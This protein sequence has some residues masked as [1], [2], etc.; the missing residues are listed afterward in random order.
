MLKS[1]KSIVKYFEGEICKVEDVSEILS[2]LKPSAL[3][4]QNLKSGNKK[5]W[6]DVGGLSL[7]KDQ[8]V[9]SL[10][11]PTKVYFSRGLCQDKTGLK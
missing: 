2:E 6:S 3:W 7:V 8:L 10:L 5:G 9:Q 1:L 11:W 4:G